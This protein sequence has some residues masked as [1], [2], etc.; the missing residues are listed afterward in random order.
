MPGISAS[1]LIINQDGSVYHLG[2]QPGDLAHDVI[3]VGDQHRVDLVSKYLDKI[4]LSKQTREF[5]TVTGELGNK[6]ISIISTGIGTD[7]IDIVINEVDALFNIDFTT[8]NVK[9]DLKSINI[10]RLGTSGGVQKDLPVDSLVISKHASGL[11]GLMHMYGYVEDDSEAE[12]SN[13]LSKIVPTGIKPITTSCSVELL[14]HFKGRFMPVNTITATGFYA[15]QGRQIR[16]K[17]SVE[18]LVESISA[19]SIGENRFHN[20]EMETSGI[21]GLSK[22]LGHQAISISAILAN[23]ID[24]T[25]SNQAKQTVE[26]MIMAALEL[27]ESYS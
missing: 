6:T 14:E 23:R 16:L 21:Y 12:L 15:P 7:N 19:V 3:T 25:F 24:Q 13:A 27:W 26:D 17:P 1:E 22:L 4:L 9:P 11:E 10:I 5:K 20:L 2:L 8:K 18:N